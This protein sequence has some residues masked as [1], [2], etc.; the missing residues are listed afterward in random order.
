MNSSTSSTF[1][2]FLAAARVNTNVVGDEQDFLPILHHG[3]LLGTSDRVWR[4]VQNAI[5]IKKFLVSIFVYMGMLHRP[6]R[7]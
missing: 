4:S 6:P 5:T 1:D 3:S 2:N 7:P